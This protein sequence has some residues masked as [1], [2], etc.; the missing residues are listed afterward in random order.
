MKQEH[1]NEFSY[2]QTDVSAPIHIY[3]GAC[4]IEAGGDKID[5]TCNVTVSWHPNFVIRCVATSSFV[6][7]NTQEGAFLTLVEWGHRVALHVDSIVFSL[8][9][10]GGTTQLLGR[11]AQQGFL[12]SDQKIVLQD[13]IFHIVNLN[14]IHF[15]ER[16]PTGEYSDANTITLNCEDWSI[17]LFKNFD[18][19]TTYQKL[20]HFN[21]FAITHMVSVQRLTPLNEGLETI[22]DEISQFLIFFL[23]FHRGMW[24]SACLPV[25]INTEGK[26]LF[27][28][29]QGASVD[30]WQTI[31]DHSYTKSSLDLQHTVEEFWNKWRSS[32]WH[33]ALKMII[34]WYIESNTLSG[35]LQGSIV[36]QQAAFERFAWTLK[37][38]GLAFFG[39]SDTK[40]NEMPASK[41][42]SETLKW[43]QIQDSVPPYNQ[44]IIAYFER[45]QKI[46]SGPD[47]LVDIRNGLVHPKPSRREM[48][49]D[50]S[51]GML[52]EVHRLGQSYLKQLIGKLI[53]MPEMIIIFPEYKLKGDARN[54]DSD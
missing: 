34:H 2:T 14:D 54:Q 30:F 19:D 36:Q 25:G 50:I 21:G 24:I 41:K 35:G 17:K 45:K 38:N 28:A 16:T 18:E 9:D 26:V 5:G 13:V 40:F 52:F 44:N 31:P 49:S 46:T 15:Y 7:I 33:D 10:G 3:E 23:S 37:E 6:H 11:L 53:N 12:F 32:E 39:L 51:A 8:T 29:L 1:L 43:A 42:I 22:I 47:L 48:L 4:V 27:R 20:E